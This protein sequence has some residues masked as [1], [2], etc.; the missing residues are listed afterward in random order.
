MH[1]GFMLAKRI[2]SLKL[3]Y[4]LVRARDTDTR[5][6]RARA[7]AKWRRRAYTEAR[8]RSA[9]RRFPAFASAPPCL[10]NQRPSLFARCCVVRQYELWVSV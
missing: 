10:K 8:P 1:R 7:V 3:R 9:S 5:R 6:T 4:R 2:L